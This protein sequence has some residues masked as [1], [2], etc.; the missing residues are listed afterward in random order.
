MLKTKKSFIEGPLFFRMLAFAIPIVLTGVLQI[1]YSMAD[2]IVV[3]RFSSDPYALAAVG[4][5]SSLTNLVLNI[6]L[7]IAAGTGVVVAQYYGA[8]EYTFVNETVHTAVTFSALG[9]VAVGAL[10]FIISEPVLILMGTK[11]EVI[12]GA[13]LYFRIISI[14]IPASSMYNF[15]A[16]VLRSVGNSKTPLIILATSGFINVLFNLFFV[17]VCGMSVGGVALATIIS[18]YLS[19][20]AVLFVLYRKRGECYGFTPKRLGI[21]KR[22]L[23]RM[24]RFGIPA[25]IQSCMFSL[26]N[27]FITGA[28]N[29]FSSPDPVTAYTIACNIDS[30]S[31]TV[32]NAFSQ[33]AMTFTGQ[34]FGAGK[35]KRINKVLL[36]S[37]LQVFAIGILVTQ[38]QIYFAETIS[39]FF[40]SPDLE[41]RDAVLAITIDISVVLLS[42][43]FIC[44]LLDVIGGA[45]RGIGYSLSPMMVN[46]VGI[47]GVRI[48]YIFL[49]FPLEAL[50]TPIG[51]MYCYPLSWTVAL[52]AMAAIRIFAGI[53]LRRIMPDGD[54]KT[55]AVKEA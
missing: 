36:Y 33:T 21:N 27:V 5:T 38:L 14:G 11:S 4:S 26:S 9:G 20:A 7:G 46:I 16:A 40:M 24:L 31:F 54:K 49:L 1:V 8:K 41:S 23:A 32:M 18:Q 29:S 35:R 47:C 25:G 6:L 55:E 3:G 52:L 44:G 34:N 51:L 2:N 28:I 50:H 48:V 15:G 13:V 22:H 37:L 30:I 17:I 45:L 42:T 19:A 12:A 10:S 43:Y 39:G 53:R